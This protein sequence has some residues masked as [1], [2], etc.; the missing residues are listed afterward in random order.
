MTTSLQGGPFT[1]GETGTLVVTEH[2]TGAAWLTGP[3]TATVTLPS[4]LTFQSAAGANWSCSADRQTV[5]CTNPDNMAP[6]A[7]SVITMQVM[8]GADA[9][10]SVSVNVAAS[11]DSD[12]AHPR[13]QTA[14]L[15]I[16][17]I[18]PETALPVVVTDESGDNSAL[19]FNH[20]AVPTKHAAAPTAGASDA[21]GPSRNATDAATAS[22]AA[23]RTLPVTGGPEAALAL[24]AGTFLA[25]GAFGIARSHRFAKQHPSHT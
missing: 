6:D 14:V 25:V 10:D 18:R 15:G 22:P 13:Y 11:S 17:I 5:T 12:V 21:A 2:N 7:S 3:I 16:K 24:L 9:P 19:V 4:G 8:V 23:G 20:A 1:V